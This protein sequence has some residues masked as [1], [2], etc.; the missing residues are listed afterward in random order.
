MLS[1]WEETKVSVTWEGVE[2]RDDR[3]KDCCRRTGAGGGRYVFIV[4]LRSSTSS[5]PASGARII[6]SPPHECKRKSLGARKP[7]VQ[8]VTEPFTIGPAVGSP[9]LIQH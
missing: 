2:G 7:V 3:D 4:T 1:S 5:R 8:A 9:L 6:A